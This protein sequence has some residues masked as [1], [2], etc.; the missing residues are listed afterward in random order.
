MEAQDYSNN[1][2]FYFLK[3]VNSNDVFNAKKIFKK[4]IL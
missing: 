4:D 1:L 2:P 3:N